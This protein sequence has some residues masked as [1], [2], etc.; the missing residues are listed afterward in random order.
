MGAQGTSWAAE[1]EEPVGGRRG[2]GVCLLKLRRRET[3]QAF[4]KAF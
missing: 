3:E 2:G 1:R 4:E